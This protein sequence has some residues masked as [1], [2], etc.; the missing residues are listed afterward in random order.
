MAIKKEREVNGIGIIDL[1][2]EMELINCPFGKKSP[3]TN[4]DIGR[5]Y[6][7]LY[8]PRYQLHASTH[9][10]VLVYF[11]YVTVNLYNLV[12]FILPEIF[13]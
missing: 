3:L 6:P 4:D 5:V 7:F 11:I 2:R 8:M 13:R 12:I 1:L 10:S 9:K